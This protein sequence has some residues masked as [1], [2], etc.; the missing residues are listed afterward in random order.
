[1][2]RSRLINT[3]LNTIKYVDSKA[4]NRQRNFNKKKN[5]TEHSGK[6]LNPFLADKTKQ[7]SRIT[8]IENENIISEDCFRLFY[9]YSNSKYPNKPRI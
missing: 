1:M 2:K 8:S 3:F 6:L 7:F 4:H 9:Q 5:K